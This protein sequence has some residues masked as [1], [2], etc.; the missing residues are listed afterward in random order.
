MNV[1]GEIWRCVC[2]FRVKC[3]MDGQDIK[4][5]TRRLKELRERPRGQWL[6]ML[7]ATECCLASD[8]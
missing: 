3:T 4:K 6:Q 8:V 7:K 5:I 1:P 2:V